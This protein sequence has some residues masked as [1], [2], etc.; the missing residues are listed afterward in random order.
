L[1]TRP[2]AALG[3]STLFYALV[4]KGAF[5]LVEYAI[6]TNYSWPFLQKVLT[7]FFALKLG[8]RWK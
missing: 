8:R 2:P 5:S 4:E 3:G 1:G 6:L 7:V